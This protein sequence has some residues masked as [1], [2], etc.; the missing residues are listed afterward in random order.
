[1]LGP[2]RFQLIQGKL[3]QIVDIRFCSP[4][5]LPIGVS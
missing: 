3:P 5:H 4:G 1:L 2:R